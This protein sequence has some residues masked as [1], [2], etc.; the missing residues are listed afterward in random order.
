MDWLKWSSQL[1][2]EERLRRLVLSIGACSLYMQWARHYLQRTSDF[3]RENLTP[4]MRDLFLEDRIARPFNPDAVKENL[5]EMDRTLYA[6]WNAL[7]A[8]LAETRELLPPGS[9]PDLIVQVEDPP[10]PPTPR[11]P[12]H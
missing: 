10:V 9:M 5:D 2:D 6:A 8:T 7:L 3:M 1:T 4:Q 12:R 11:A